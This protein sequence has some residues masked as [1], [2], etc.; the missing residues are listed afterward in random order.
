MQTNRGD[1]RMSENSSSILKEILDSI[2]YPNLSYRSVPK[3]YNNAQNVNPEICRECGGECCQRCGCNFSPDDFSEISFEYLKT[4]LEKGY[5]SIEYIDGEMIYADFG[6]YILRARNQGAPIVDTDFRPR[7]PCVLWT[8]ERG[9]KLDYKHRPSGGKLLIP[10]EKIARGLWGNVR[11]CHSPYTLRNCC[12]EWRPHQRVL[13]EL[14]DY[15]KD[16]D[17]E[18]SL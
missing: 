2:L 14:I 13:S 6:I 16:K 15:F 3:D 11:D 7:T 4:Q 18:C 10:S 12:N 17:F 8:K 1:E 5:I 9:C